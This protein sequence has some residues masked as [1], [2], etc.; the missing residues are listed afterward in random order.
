[1]LQHCFFNSFMIHFYLVESI[2]RILYILSTSYI[3]YI[4]NTARK[5]MLSSLSQL[6]EIVSDVHIRR[7]KAYH[8][9]F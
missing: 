4:T 3:D 1:M 5:V 7:V 8:F 9:V 6:Y 2:T